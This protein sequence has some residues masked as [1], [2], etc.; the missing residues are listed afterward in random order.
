MNAIFDRF[1]TGYLYPGPLTGDIHDVQVTTDITTA[2]VNC[3]NFPITSFFLQRGF[4]TDAVDKFKIVQAT[5]VSG[6]GV[7]D[8]TGLA[9][10]A[11]TGMDT[12]GDVACLELDAEALDVAN[13]FV[14]VAAV[15]SL[16]A[17]TGVNN[18]C[19][20]YI[21]GQARFA[22]RALNARLAADA[23]VDMIKIMN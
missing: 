16:G 8:V 11:F 5:D 9:L 22:H 10:T 3:K 6:T 1:K 7:K 23:G 17:D 13:G 14:F 4:A 15:F 20:W 12:V 21:Q 18:F 2:Y 19:L